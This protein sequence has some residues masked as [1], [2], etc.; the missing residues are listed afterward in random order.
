[1][2][3]SPAAISTSSKKRARS[4]SLNAD[5]PSDKRP[6]RAQVVV[7]DPVFYKPGGDCRIRV[8]DTLFCIHRFLLDRDSATFQT[9]FELPQGVEVPQGS[10]DEDPIVLAGDTV[11]EFRDLC[12]ALYALPDEIVNVPKKNNSLAKLANVAMLSHKYQLAAFQ[13]WSMGVI[14]EKCLAIKG[15]LESCPSHLLPAMVQLS[16]RYNDDV[17]K[18]H[19]IDIWVSRLSNPKPTKSPSFHP[20]PTSAFTH[21]LAFADDHGLRQFLVKLY[22]ARLLVAHRDSS[23]SLDSP[24]DF[25]F[26]GLKPVHLGRILRGSWM[27]SAY[28]QQLSCSPIPELPTDPNLKCPR[29]RSQC[30][31]DWNHLWRILQS[32]K[33]TGA[34]PDISRRY[35]DLQDGGK[36]EL[37]SDSD[38]G[39]YT[40]AA[41]SPLCPAANIIVQSFITKFNKDLEGYFFGS[42]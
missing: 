4:D 13:S 42:L 37:D 8:A 32:G 10:T 30:V 39:L 35:R 12:W 11:P 6:A 21:A 34:F 23:K 17:L 3:E 9:M 25:P 29:H 36:L 20:L 5:V 22:Y 41:K 7:R 38:S 40:P 19:V 28:W 16:T 27:L 2:E 24:L 31:P 1:M 26:E 18:N 33:Y 14:R 15:P